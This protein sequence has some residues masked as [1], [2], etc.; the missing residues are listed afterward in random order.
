MGNLFGTDFI[1][2]ISFSN[3]EIMQSIVQLHCPDGIELDGTYGYGHFYKT[4]QKPKYR[5]DLSPKA[6]GVEIVD[7]RKM[8]LANGII[9][10]A[11]FDPPFVLGDHKES[12]QYIMM[13]RYEAFKTIQQLRAMYKAALQE[14]YR[15]LK[16]G[17][18]LVFKCQDMAHGRQNYF[19][20]V[21]VEKMAKEIGFMAIDLFVML[22]KNRFM[23]KTHKQRY[24]RKFHCYFWIFK[25]R[26]RELKTPANLK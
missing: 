17:G 8:P 18:I 23:N 15:V 4:I 5:Y 20:H 6:S 21:E 1:S 24:A 7:C 9:K 12:E 14:Y 25:K 16:P 11:V 3:D 10:T 22:A 26:M 13:Q 2:T 19:V